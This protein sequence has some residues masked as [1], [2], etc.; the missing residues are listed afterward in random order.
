MAHKSRT[1]DKHERILGA[2]LKVFAKHGFYSSKV[3][4]IAREAGVADGTIYLYFKNKD[5]ILIKA[6]EEAMTQLIARL[7]DALASIAHP[8]DKLRT[9]IMLH[10]SIVREYKEL[11]EVITVELRQSTKFMKEYK[12]EKFKDYLKRI[13]QIIR[14]GQAEGF[15][16]QEISAGLL[17]RGIFGMIDELSL[18][19]VLSKKH[20]PE[21]LDVVVDQV[22][23]V[24]IRG[25][26]TEEGRLSL[27]KLNGK[28]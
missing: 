5:D 9:Y 25:I 23:S 7:D 11:A 10:F 1:G 20:G 13:S 24:I 3:S 14:E 17:K 22:A 2:A 16:R 6:F 26:Q 4:E 21:E 18:L 27:E 15:I 28:S 8:L 19:M 12:N